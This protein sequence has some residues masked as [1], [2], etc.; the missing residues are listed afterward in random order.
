MEFEDGSVEE[1][2]TFI[3]A[4]GYKH[5]I[6]FF[7]NDELISFE[8]DDKYFGPL[9]RRTLSIN[10]PRLCFVG[11]IDGSFLTIFM[12]ERQAIVALYG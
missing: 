1:I 4:T 6:S 10:E 9:F 8:K 7:K 12:L 2:D 3:F 5:K 11:T